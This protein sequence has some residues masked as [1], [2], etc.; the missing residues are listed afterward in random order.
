M[1][2]F[3]GFVEKIGE[4]HGTGRNGKPY[5]MYSMKLQEADGSVLDTWFKLGFN[6][7]TK[8]KEGDHIK[9]EAT[10][11]EKYNNWDVD[12]QNVKVNKNP[13][14]KPQSEF[15]KSQAAKGGAKVTESELFG[16]I[17]GYNTE[18]D[19][20]RMTWASARTAA[21]SAAELLIVGNGLKL[22]KTKPADCFDVITA[23]IDKLTVEYF[24]DSMGSL[25]KLETVDDGAEA[26]YAAEE[27][28]EPEVE[29]PVDEFDDGDDDSDFE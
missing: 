27:V 29:E 9:F 22:P 28:P 25:R 20:A 10:F 16:E 2:E 23:T 4:K 11:N 26:D 18:D 1:K 6:R 5:T 21:I 13:P 8:F 17:G 15:E 12:Q 24:N 7:P 19:V 14:K 3:I